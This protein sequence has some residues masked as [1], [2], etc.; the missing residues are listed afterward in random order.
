MTIARS[1]SVK[2]THLLTIRETDEGKVVERV[3]ACV[4][5]YLPS[6]HFPQASAEAQLERALP[7]AAE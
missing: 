5:D 4:R 1:G 7:T 3:A 2:E 6:V